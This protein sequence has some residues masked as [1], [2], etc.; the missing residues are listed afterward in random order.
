MQ[1]A[2]QHITTFVATLV[3]YCKTHHSV[4][5]QVQTIEL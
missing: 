1:Q 5:D 3:F 2:S 4:Q